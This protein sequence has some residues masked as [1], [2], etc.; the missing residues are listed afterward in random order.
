MTLKQPITQIIKQR[1]SVR[2]YP[3]KSLEAKHLAALQECLASNLSGAFQSKLRFQLITAEPGDADALK[4]LGTYGQIKHPAGFIIGAMGTSAKNLEDFGYAMEQIVLLATDLGVGTCWLGGSFQ[5]SNFA[6]AMQCA[7]SESVPAAISIGYPAEK[8]SWRDKLIHVV[9]DTK[10]RFPWE[11]LFFLDSFQTPLTQAQAGQYATPLE[12]VRLAPSASN[13][14]PWRIV[15]V[16]N[17]FH[18]YL[19]RTMKYHPNGKGWFQ[20]ADMQRMDIGIAMCHF[21]LTAREQGLQGTWKIV[22]PG[23]AP[24]PA[25]TEYVASWYVNA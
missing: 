18:F 20:T 13:K 4:G 17:A 3:Q 11:Q 25:Q 1:I 8:P 19:Q 7:A 9:I 14:Q 6:N 16:G 2:T 23:I 22:D 12:M 15:T 24:L 10:K 5:Q 21:E